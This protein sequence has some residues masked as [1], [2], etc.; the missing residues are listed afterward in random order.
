MAAHSFHK[1]QSMKSPE[2]GIVENPRLLVERRRRAAERLIKIF[3]ADISDTQNGLND[4]GEL[5]AKGGGLA[6]L[7]N[8]FSWRDGP[9]AFVYIAAQN[10]MLIDKPWLAPVAW[11]IYDVAKF[12][13]QHLKTEAE[14]KRVVTASTVAKPKYAHL[15][16]GYGLIDYIRGAVKTLDRGGVVVLFPQTSRKPYLAEPKP[17]DRAMK[18]LFDSARIRK[19]K[20]FGVLPVGLSIEGAKDYRK[21][22]K[23]N[24][25]VSY[26]VNIGRLWLESEIREAVKGTG[27]DL[28]TWGVQNLLRPL[29]LENYLKISQKGDI[30]V[31]N[32]SE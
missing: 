11:H 7:L 6:I 16:Q 13:N 32:K 17:K 22:S 15:T 8:H 1:L 14:L 23:V 4:A 19:I 10:E 3:P 31:A 2:H 12:L 29:V 25:G 28:D 9:G 21:L 5:V 18:L 24:V 26:N 27:Q 20:T 30:F